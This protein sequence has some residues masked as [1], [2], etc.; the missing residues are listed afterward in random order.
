MMLAHIS[1][2]FSS[3]APRFFDSGSSFQAAMAAT[4]M[5]MMVAMVM[6]MEME[7]MEMEMT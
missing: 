2:H 3:F 5:V 6:M 4:I 7:M 1:P